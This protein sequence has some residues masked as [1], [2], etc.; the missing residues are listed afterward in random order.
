MET[1]TNEQWIASF[2]RYLKRRFPGRTTAKHYISD[3]RIFLKQYTGSILNVTP[4]DVD[5]FVDGQQMREL[6]V[7]TVNRRVSAA[8]IAP[9]S[10][11]SVGPS[12]LSMC[13]SGAS[14]SS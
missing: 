6:A 8:R 7:T 3:M 4:A 13:S 14:S 11:G 12:S 2:E 1:S 5:A 9:G 10:A